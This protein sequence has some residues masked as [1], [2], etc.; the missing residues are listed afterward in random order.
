[1]HPPGRSLT[2]TP[3]YSPDRHPPPG[4]PDVHTYTIHQGPALGNHTHYWLVSSWL[5]RFRQHCSRPSHRRAA[6]SPTYSLGGSSVA[7][8]K[9]NIYPKPKATKKKVNSFTNRC[10]SMVL[11]AKLFVFQTNDDTDS[12]AIVSTCSSNHAKLLRLHCVSHIISFIIFSFCNGFWTL[13][14]GHYD[15][16]SL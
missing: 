8:N 4:S 14:D 12:I 2:E 13:C 3:P 6:G 16:F 9:T 15:I 1:M 7:R 5:T 11:K 10:F